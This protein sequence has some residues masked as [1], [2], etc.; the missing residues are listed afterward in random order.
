MINQ[1]ISSVKLRH[2]SIV[3]A[4]VDA[5]VTSTNQGIV[6]T[7]SPDHFKHRGR[8]LTKFGI[9]DVAI[10]E[11]CGPELRKKFCKNCPFHWPMGD[12]IITDSCL[13][14]PKQT[15]FDKACCRFEKQ[16]S[17]W[18]ELYPPHS[19]TLAGRA[20]EA[21]TYDNSIFLPPNPS[22]RYIGKRPDRDT[23]IFNF[24]IHANCPV[25]WHGDECTEI[26]YNV[27]CD[28]FKMACKH[29]KIS[30]IALPGLCCGRCGIE[31]CLSAEV[32][33]KAM[34]KYDRIGALTNVEFWFDD[35]RV[36]NHF[37]KTFRSI[38]P[39]WMI[40]NDEKNTHEELNCTN[41]LKNNGKVHPSD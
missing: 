1:T 19:T 32:A 21:T 5:V 20:K 10:H 6:S 25:F 39:P 2:G 9:N 22:A 33:S 11:H 35:V 15:R 41:N 13:K 8:H 4:C 7:T 30:T 29:P 17:L 28:I 40:E 24:V 3:N 27:Y 18:D 37:N 34:L 26:I 36:S 38:L 31:P 16:Y 14:K 23:G 12:V